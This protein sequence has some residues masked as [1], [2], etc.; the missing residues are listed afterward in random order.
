MAYGLAH[1]DAPNQWVD[2]AVT[3]LDQPTGAS[4][5]ILGIADA[6]PTEGGRRF[7]IGPQ[8][9]TVEVAV[10]GEA[11]VAEFPPDLWF[12]GWAGVQP[13]FPGH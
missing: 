4:F 9:S 13:P 2:V 7:L 11:L 12:A 1:A 10:S 5:A 6:A 8:D 3:G